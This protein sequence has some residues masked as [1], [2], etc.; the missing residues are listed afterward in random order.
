MSLAIITIALATQL[1]S[2]V[3]SVTPVWTGH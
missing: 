1:D 3:A 2:W